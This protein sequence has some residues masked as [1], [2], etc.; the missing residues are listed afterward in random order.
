MLLD[1]IHTHVHSYHV[2][3]FSITCT[4]LV[5]RVHI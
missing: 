2:G 5:L 3:T 4:H 1:D